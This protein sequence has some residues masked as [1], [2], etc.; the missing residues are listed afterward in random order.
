MRG[1]AVAQPNAMPTPSDWEVD[2][3]PLR[4][5]FYTPQGNRKDVY[6]VLWKGFAADAGT[7]EPMSS[8]NEATVADPP[9]RVNPRASRPQA[10]ALPP[11]SQPI[12][13]NHTHKQRSSHSNST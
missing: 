13:L 7:W 2:R 1:I 11:S 4:Y 8:L 3:V 12:S 6:F 5:S 9:T 10:G